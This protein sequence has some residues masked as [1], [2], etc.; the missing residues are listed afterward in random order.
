MTTALKHFYEA[1]DDF[2]AFLD[3]ARQINRP[4][5][6]YTITA[7]H[8]RLRAMTL[9]FEELIGFDVTATTLARCARSLSDAANAVAWER[10]PIKSADDLTAPPPAWA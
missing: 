10:R 3:E 7:L 5:G 1:C 4:L 6:G 9:K 8:E 2:F